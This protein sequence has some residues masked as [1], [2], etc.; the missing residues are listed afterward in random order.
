MHKKDWKKDIFTIPNMLSLFRLLLIPVYVALYLNADPE[1]WSDHLVAAGVLAVSCL[2]DLLDGKIARHFN[3]ISTIGKIL[4]PLADK[5][6]QFTMIICLL[7]KY[8][9]LKWLVILFVV[10]EIF[11]LIG[12][13]HILRRRMI[14]KGA[15]LTGKISTAILFISLIVMIMLPQIETTYVTIIA[16][17]DSLVLLIAMVDY[18]RAFFT[19][20]TMLQTFDEEIDQGH[21]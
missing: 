3:M 2:T 9:V 7:I 6:T 18:A 13:I 16:A 19:N 11:Q 10:K 12:G 1:S 4:D 17:V 14:L 5:I 20:N 8:P 15:L 21:L